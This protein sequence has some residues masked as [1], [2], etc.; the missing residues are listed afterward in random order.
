MGCSLIHKLAL[1]R[2]TS[3]VQ[4]CSIIGSLPQPDTLKVPSAF[5]LVTD[6]DDLARLVD[7]QALFAKNEG[8]I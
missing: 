7:Q 5:G 4:I 8:V 6:A 2:S 1:P 3:E